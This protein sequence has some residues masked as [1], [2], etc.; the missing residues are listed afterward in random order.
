LLPFATHGEDH[1][2]FFPTRAAALKYGCKVLSLKK[3]NVENGIVWGFDAHDLI[4][5]I[6][7]LEN[8]GKL[9]RKN[10]L[11]I[12]SWYNEAKICFDDLLGNGIEFIKVE[13]EGNTGTGTLQLIHSYWG[14]KKDRFVPVFFETKS[15]HISGRYL[16]DLNV[17]YEIHK[18]DSKQV[19]LTLNYRYLNNNPKHKSKYS[20]TESLTWNDSLFSFYNPELERRKLIEAKNPIQ[21]RIIE[22]RLNYMNQSGN[23]KTISVDLL[24][25]IKMMQILYDD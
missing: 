20:W 13:F 4:I 14:W 21:K 15:Y 12:T 24:N 10:Q 25:E 3:R 22:A 2:S 8:D 6:Y 18:K 1:P 5:S 7:D 19:S 11:K 23:M 16:E 9:V 17:N